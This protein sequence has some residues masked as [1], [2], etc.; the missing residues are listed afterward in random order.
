MNSKSV[1]KLALLHLIYLLMKV[2]NEI[3]FREVKYLE[4]ILQEEDI[5]DE[6]L[7]DF[8]AQ[9]S[10]LTE[11][12]IFNRGIKL[13]GLC[14][15]GERIR[16]YSNLRTMAAADGKFHESELQFLTQIGMFSSNEISIV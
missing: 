15:E 14:T 9:L 10:K 11:Q 16:I 1:F 12:E 8:K 7:A 5:S 2:D 4:R 13:I 6:L 3:D